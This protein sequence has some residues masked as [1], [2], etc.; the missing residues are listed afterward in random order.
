VKQDHQ[1]RA[2]KHCL[3]LKLRHVPNW[4]LC[5]AARVHRHGI[6]YTG[7]R[8]GEGRTSDGCERPGD[9]VDR[10]P[11]NSLTGHVDKLA[12]RVDRHTRQREIASHSE[13]RP[14]DGHECPGGRIDR[15]P[16]NIKGIGIHDIGEL[17][18]RVH[19]HGLRVLPRSEGRT[20]DGRERPRGRVKV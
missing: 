17:A 2:Q 3:K 20:G 14:G 8:E 19:R 10:V 12:V 18:A 9:R 13:G 11:K 15:V 6:G 7:R 4:Y 5:L 1:G 16:R